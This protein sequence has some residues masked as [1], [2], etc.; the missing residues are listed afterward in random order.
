MKVKKTKVQSILDRR[1]RLQNGVPESCMS[2]DDRSSLLNTVAE[3]PENNDEA[4]KPPE[5][6]DFILEEPQPVIE[7]KKRNTRKGP[8]RQRPVEVKTQGYKPKSAMDRRKFDKSL[9]EGYE[10]RDRNEQFLSEASKEFYEW[11]T[12]GRMDDIQNLQ[13]LLA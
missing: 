1:T 12:N 9:F 5:E 3:I 13:R 11:V 4:K 10:N 7:K 8:I 2:E 6:P